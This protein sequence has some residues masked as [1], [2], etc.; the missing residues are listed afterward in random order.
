MAIRIK[1]IYEP[2]NP[3][4]GYRILI[5]RLWP[6]GIKKE[7]AKVDLWHKEIAPTTKLRT[8]FSHDPEKWEEFQKM[9]RQ[10]LKNNSALTDLQHLAKQHDNLTLL[11]AATDEKHNHAI[12]LSRLLT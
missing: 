10:E 11:F 2:A 7:Q 6:R 1:R 9:Y 8:W 3:E 4:D 12:V 5:D